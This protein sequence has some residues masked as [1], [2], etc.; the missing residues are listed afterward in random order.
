MTAYHSAWRRCATYCRHFGSERAFSRATTSPVNR[1]GLP[2][3]KATDGG[4]PPSGGR[5]A[6]TRFRTGGR[7]ARERDFGV[8]TRH[9]RQATVIHRTL[10]AVDRSFV[11]ISAGGATALLHSRV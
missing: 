7:T 11:I 2:L 10:M 4:R 1:R 5:R 9:Y 6:T 3:A 8:L